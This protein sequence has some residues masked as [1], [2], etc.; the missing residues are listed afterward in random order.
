M[1]AVE[2]KTIVNYCVKKLKERSHHDPEYFTSCKTGDAFELRVVEVLKVCLVELQLDAEIQHTSGSHVFPDIVIAFPT[3]EKYGIEVKSLSSKTKGWK[4]NGNSVLGST[5]NEEVLETY[6][7]LGKISREYLD[8]RTRK[9]EE[10]ISNVVVTHSPRYLI[11]MDLD[12]GNTFFDKSGITYEEI[13]DSDNPIRLIT[14][15]YLREGM[16]AWWLSDSSPAALR[17]FSDISQFEKRQLIGYGLAHFPELFVDNLNK[18]KRFAFWL[19]TD[20]SIITHNLRDLFSAGGQVDLEFD[21]QIY[22]KLPKKFKKLDEYKSYLISS[23][24]DSSLEDLLSDWNCDSIENVISKSKLDL[25]I[26]VASQFI[27]KD[28]LDNISPSELLENILK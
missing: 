10:C 6:V 24:E 9:Y 5:R 21:G 15:Y 1:S 12:E 19:A 25:W 2:F 11:D 17:M 8:F 20:K 28:T 26:E 27:N 13:N 4:I 22:S 16:Q 23:L 7:L 14:N 18:Y 3:G